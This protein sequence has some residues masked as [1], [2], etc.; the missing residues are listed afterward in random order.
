MLDCCNGHST[1]VFIK[2]AGANGEWIS[3]SSKMS[4]SYIAEII[5][6]LQMGECPVC[7]GKIPL[8]KSKEL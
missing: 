1:Y 4:L 3:G 7:T 6:D 5:D 8:T 2:A